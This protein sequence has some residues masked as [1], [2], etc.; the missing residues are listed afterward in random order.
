MTPKLSA[1]A[2]QP[3]NRDWQLHDR[4]M[5]DYYVRNREKLLAYAR[6][7][8]EAKREEINAARRRQGRKNPTR[9]RLMKYGL[10]VEDFNHMADVQQHKCA[11]CR[12]PFQELRKRPSVDHNH[13]NGYIR[14][15]LCHRC[16]LGLGQF[17]E[18]PSI[19]RAAADYIEARVPVDA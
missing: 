3:R 18:D 2:A 4:Y 16:N 9:D 5:K 12:V 13:D 7:R 17:K 11:I 19:L 1:G 14:G 10:A 6:A 8:L 15:L